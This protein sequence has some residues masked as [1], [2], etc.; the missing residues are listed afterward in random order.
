MKADRFFYLAII[1]FVVTNSCSKSPA[2]WGDDK[3]EGLIEKYYTTHDF[4]MCFETYV[5][6]YKQ[7][8]ITSEE[9][10]LNI[11]DS[12]CY[13]LPEAGYSS[14]PPDIDFNTHSLL[15]FYASGQCETKFIRKVSEDES[16]KK[17]TYTIEV[18]DCGTC[19]SMRT[20]ANLVLVTKLPVGYTVDFIL[21]DKD[22]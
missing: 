10:L 12:N 2:C 5:N 6:E 4:P 14:V 15:G 3:N 13:N 8:V 11:I 9:E 1:L 22:K 17:Y 7:V 18:K 16:D 19:K 21:K 20:D